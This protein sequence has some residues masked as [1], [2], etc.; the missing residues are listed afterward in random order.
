[1]AKAALELELHS[2]A[3]PRRI[4]VQ[5]ICEGPSMTRQEFTEECDVNNIMRNYDRDMLAFLAVARGEPS[6]VDFSQMPDTLQGVMNFM[7]DAENAFMQ[8]PAIARREFDN[9]PARFVEYA[10]D[11]KNVDKLREWGLAAPAKVA[12]APMRVEVVNPPAGGG[13]LAGGDKKGA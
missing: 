7:M 2:A 3:N 5:M 11:A 8:I 4:D 10:S 13:D 9:D 12:D 1:M 6:Y